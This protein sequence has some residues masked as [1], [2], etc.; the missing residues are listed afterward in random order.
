MREAVVASSGSSGMSVRK[1]CL[2][3]PAIAKLSH[4]VFRNLIVPGGYRGF[5]ISE[6]AVFITVYGERDEEDLHIAVLSRAPTRSSDRVM[7]C[8]TRERVFRRAKKLRADQLI[9]R[10]A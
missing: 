1:I 6:T 4:S 7:R 5:P 9:R 8:A 2:A 10:I 3:W